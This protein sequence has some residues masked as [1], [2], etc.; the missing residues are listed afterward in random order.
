[1]TAQDALITVSVGCGFRLVAEAVATS[2]AENADVCVVS[3]GTDLAELTVPPGTKEPDVAV[4]CYYQAGWDAIDLCAEIKSRAERTKVVLGGPREPAS[5]L[6][7]AVLAGADGFVMD[8][9][10]VTALVDAVRDVHAGKSRVPGE[11]LGS[12][13]RGLIE[14]RRE[15]DILVEKFASLGRR[16]KEVLIAMVSGASDADIAKRMY[17]SAH[18]VRT[19]ARNVLKKLGFHSRAEAARAVLGHDL[20]ARFGLASESA[21]LPAGRTGRLR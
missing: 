21:P 15:D 14:F 2:L 20:I 7:T 16:E 10:P 3:V 11:M 1:M 17:L 12:L 19:H 8:G 9:E 5:I 13:L 18:T 4:L 6:Q